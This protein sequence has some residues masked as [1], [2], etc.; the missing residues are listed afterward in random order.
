MLVPSSS[1]A[2]KVGLNV[3]SKQF[4]RFSNRNDEAFKKARQEGFED[5]VVEH[6]QAL[7]RIQERLDK[8][9]QQAE[10]IAH[11]QERVARLEGDPQFDRVQDNYGYEAYREAMKER[12]RMLAYA[13]AGSLPA[14]LTIG[15]L[16]RVERTI[17]ELD[18]VDVLV[19]ADLER[20]TRSRRGT[21]SDPVYLRWQKAGASGSM[22]VAAGCV[23]VGAQGGGFGSAPLPVAEITEI[24]RWVLEVLADYIEVVRAETATEGK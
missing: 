19:L 3:L 20:E 12:R 10:E 8:S 23:H 16:A 18:P 15:Q 21:P 11:L 14:R 13:A 24:G 7:R 17:R 1:L 9:D 6:A 22:L 5:F 2:L 4:D